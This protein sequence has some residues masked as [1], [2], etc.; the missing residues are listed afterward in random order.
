MSTAVAPP[1]ALILGA[2]TNIGAHVAR[3]FAAKGYRVASTSRTSRDQG[4]T[5]NGDLHL[6]GDLAD[7]GSIA[8]IFAKVGDLL[9]PPS[10]VV[11]NGKLVINI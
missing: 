9:G 2:G 5:S 4:T 7:P 6:Q 11:Y 1:V 8:G 10:V 3:S